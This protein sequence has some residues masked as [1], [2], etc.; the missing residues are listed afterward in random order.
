[1]IVGCTKEGA[2]GKTQ[3]CGKSERC[4][5][6]QDIKE[7]IVC[8]TKVCDEMALSCGNGKQSDRVKVCH[9]NALIDVVNCADYSM[10]CKNGMCVN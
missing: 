8:E 7:G 3:A 10:T 4:V 1:M 2:M 9:N 6:K 5:D